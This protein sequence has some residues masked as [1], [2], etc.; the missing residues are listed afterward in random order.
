MVATDGFGVAAMHAVLPF[1]VDTFAWDND[2]K[3]QFVTHAHKDQAVDIEK[4]AT[5]LWCTAI[6][7]ELLLIRFPCLARARTTFHILQ[8]PDPQDHDFGAAMEGHEAQQVSGSICTRLNA[9]RG[10]GHTADCRPTAHSATKRVA[11]SARCAAA[12]GDSQ[13]RDVHCN[14][15]SI[16]A[17]RR[18]CHA[19]VR[20]MCTQL[21]Q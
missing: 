2:E 8:M 12:G 17:L 11:R 1:T 9:T 20:G 21:C 14:G 6:T 19:A 13:R 18:R 7:K 5:D 3:P 10:C 16:T 15:D 4:Y